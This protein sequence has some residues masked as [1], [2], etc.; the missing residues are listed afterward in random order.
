MGLEN[1]MSS[2]GNPNWCKP[3]VPVPILR[4]EFEQ[5]VEKLGLHPCEYQASPQLKNWCRRNANS[6][7]VPEDLLKLWGIHVNES[8]GATT[9][10]MLATR[11]H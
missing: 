7:Y 2:R 11:K 4:T 5:Q 9:E 8:W 3:N 1:R 10:Y 6:H